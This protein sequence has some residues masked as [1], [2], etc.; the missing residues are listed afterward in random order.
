MPT[1]LLIADHHPVV[2]KGLEV[3]FSEYENF[4]LLKP[5]VDTQQLLKFLKKEA[6]TVDVIILEIDL[7]GAS[8]F[9]V[10]KK[11]KEDYPGIRIVIFTSQSE[12]MF[13]VSSLKAGA[14]GFISKKEPLNNI[15]Q[16]VTK[17]VNGGVYISHELAQSIAIDAT[18]GRPRKMYGK[19]SNREVEILK[20]LS[21]GRRIIDI[22]YE[23][24]IS[25]KTV[26]TYKRRIMDKLKVRSLVELIYVAQKMKVEAL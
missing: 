20:M 1:N 11:I 10:L 16:A 9:S 25:T 24:D 13:S 23:L 22:A 12:D 21:D 3:L 2:H 6:D 14:S 26:S 4:Q 8:S 18:T 5:I 19:L 17:V 7:P 15:V